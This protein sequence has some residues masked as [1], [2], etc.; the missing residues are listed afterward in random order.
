MKGDSPAGPSL[1]RYEALEADLADVADHL[2]KRGIDR[3]ILLGLCSGADDSMWLADQQQFAG[4][5][6]LDPYCRRSARYYL[7]RYG[8]KLLSTAPMR[9]LAKRFIASEKTANSAAPSELNMRD[10]SEA[11]ALEAHLAQY[12]NGG[13]KVLAI[14]TSSVDDYYAYEGQFLSGYRSH[15][16]SIV[17]QYLREADH[18]FSLAIDRE[19]LL[20]EVRAWLLKRC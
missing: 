12:L 13:G 10:W 17:E 20:E 16:A 14:F 8:P 1:G 4:I 6:L 11:P 15:Q 5:I 7:E 9:R 19:R 2:K 18:L 3:L